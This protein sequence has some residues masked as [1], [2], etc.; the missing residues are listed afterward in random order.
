MAHPR[1]FIS[2]SSLDHE[3]AAAV[4]SALEGAG[5]PCWMA[6]RDILPGDKWGT[7]IVQAVAAS[8]VMV[9]VFSAHANESEQVERELELAA[10]NKVRILTF[11]I[12]NVQPSGVL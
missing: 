3:V 2:H 1:V 8:R 11:R 4:C 6:P 10:D 7:T 12:E 5:I 9:L